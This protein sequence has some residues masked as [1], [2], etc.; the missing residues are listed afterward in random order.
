MPI[1]HTPARSR[2]ATMLGTA[3]LAAAV[4]PL[5]VAA[6]APDNAS[7]TASAPSA[8]APGDVVVDEDFSSGRL[9]DGWTA[10]EGQWA[11]SGGRLYGTSTSSGQQS[12]I[13]FGRHLAD[14]R[15]E[16]T[17]RFETAADAGRWTALGLD[18]PADGAVPWSI[19]TMRTGTTA[20]NGIEFA[21]R[22]AANAWNVTDTGSAPPPRPAP[23]ATSRSPSRC[24][25]APHAG[26]ST[27]AKS[28]APPASSAP[29]TA[30]KPCWSTGPRWPSTTS[31]SP[32]WRPAG[33]CARPVRRSP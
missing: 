28:C 5:T 3:V 23:D 22:T 27:A 30:A 15:F 26:S 7:A 19:A 8:T 14:F 20:A 12:R 6:A 32:R 9:P 2:R 13:T 21:Q 18:V 33:I 1:T 16:A 11:V 17:A 10:V 4:L 25:A 24:T 31:G 29:P